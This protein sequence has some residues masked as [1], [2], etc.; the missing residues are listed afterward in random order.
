MQVSPEELSNSSLRQCF[1]LGDTA[2]AKISRLIKEAVS[3]GII[4][5]FDTETSQRY[6]KYIPGWA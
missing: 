6:M 2:S 5:P 1:G 3:I 4:K